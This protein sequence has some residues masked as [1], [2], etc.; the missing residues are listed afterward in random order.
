MFYISPAAR[1]NQSLRLI[2]I[3]EGVYKVFVLQKDL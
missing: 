3:E 1:K 2:L